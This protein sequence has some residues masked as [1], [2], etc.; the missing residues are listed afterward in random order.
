MV[1][2]KSNAGYKFA[3]MGPSLSKN[4][5]KVQKYHFKIVKG[6][7]WVAVGICHKDI[8]VKNKYGFNFSNLGHGGYMVSSNG[9]VWSNI[10]E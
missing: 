9:G 4:T 8:V 3:I 5:L 6:S 2:S 1:A 7:D 10:H